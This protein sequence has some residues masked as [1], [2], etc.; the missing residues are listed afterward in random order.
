[1]AGLWQFFLFSLS[2]ISPRPFPRHP[3]LGNLM[4]CFWSNQNDLNRPL[5]KFVR[6]IPTTYQ[7]SP[8]TSVISW[9]RKEWRRCQENVGDQSRLHPIPL[10]T[11]SCTSHT[12]RSTQW[13]R[14]KILFHFRHSAGFLGKITHPQNKINIVGEAGKQLPDQ[15]W[16]LKPRLQDE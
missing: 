14:R 15:G 3:S 5:T 10:P 8:H 16:F 13:F 9:P 1:M 4:G 6:K 2:L 12:S 11:P 7:G